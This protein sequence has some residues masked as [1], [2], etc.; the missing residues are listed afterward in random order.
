MMRKM[1]RF[2]AVLVA[3]AMAF[4]VGTAAFAEQAT[5]ETEQSDITTYADENV[6]QAVNYSDTVAVDG[7]NNTYTSVQ[8]AIDAHKGTVGLLKNVSENVTVKDDTTI[9]FRGCTLTAADSSE[10]VINAADGSL[11]LLDS[12]ANKQGGTVGEIAAS[13]LTINSG[14][15]R[16]SNGAV[17]SFEDRSQYIA[18]ELRVKEGTF[19]GA[20]N[21]PVFSCAG[22]VNITCYAAEIHTGEGG[23]VVI[24]KSDIVLNLTFDSDLGQSA[25]SVVYG[26]LGVVSSSNVKIAV[27]SGKFDH[28]IEPTVLPGDDYSMVKEGDFWVLKRDTSNDVAVVTDGAYYEIAMDSLAQALDYAV[29]R[30]RTDGKYY[31]V[32][33]YKD[34]TENILLSPAKPESWDGQNRQVTLYMNGHTLTAADPAKAALSVD[35]TG[36][37][38]N[39]S[40]AE[41][42]QD[43]DGTIN[44]RVESNSYLWLVHTVV[45]AAAG[46]PAVVNTSATNDQLAIKG[47]STINGAAGQAVVVSNGKT[48]IGDEAV[49]KAG[50]NGILFMR[51]ESA[52]AGATCFDLSFC[53]LYGDLGSADAVAA[54]NIMT[55]KTGC[56]VRFD[57]IPGAACIPAGWAPVKKDDGLYWLE[58]ATGLTVADKKQDVAST[59]DTAKTAVP[60]V[61]ESVPQ[62]LLPTQ[63]Q[64]SAKAEELKAELTG[65]NAAVQNFK[66]NNLSGV[67]DVKALD[68]V[69]ADSIV[70]LSVQVQLQDIQLGASVAKD[71]DGKATGVKLGC[72]MLQF[73]VTP[74]FSVDG[75]N[76]AV[77]PNNKLSGGDV[78]FRLPIPA[79]I[80]EKYAVV[81]HEG[82]A[83]RY[84]EVKAENDKKYIELSA[85]HFSVFTVSFTDELPAAPTAAP[86]L[87]TNSS[88]AQPTAT[89]APA[90]KQ[91]DSA[92]YTCKACG[93]HDWTAIEGGYKCDHCGYVESVK[94]LAG[95]PNVKGT[96][97]VGSTA[98]AK[99]AKT[100]TSAIPQTA[101][102]MPVTALTVLAL[103]ALLGMGVTAAKRKQ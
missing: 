14:V 8:A 64:V 40:I 51:G 72:R 7:S 73:D 5:P 44:G 22:K 75:G 13:T 36:L 89:A 11:T 28:E 39:G 78:K 86:T 99:P 79:E 4:S 15:Y 37:M 96:A 60:A 27:Y 94:Q 16:A 62:E 70:E 12:D 100:T 58:P 80:T 42:A 103:A 74:M 1:K 53:T 88:E 65:D 18:S 21:M 47:R 82:D 68:G 17:I 19:Y 25:P 90:V 3:A 81:S 56:F 35:G 92:Y 24:P 54:T 98:A 67:V 71:A 20:A 32:N 2:S 30:S 48:S 77:I 85:T 93:Y 87:N 31:T 66:D 49:L 83:D 9:D 29:Y 69:K 95:Y 46:Q 41:A 101:D 61:A 38:L 97:T 63:E 10:P 84:V 102:E 23:K 55:G 57:R 91:D 43:V 59:V 76:A 33:L 6:D 26:E 50:E 34:V 45:N 52:P